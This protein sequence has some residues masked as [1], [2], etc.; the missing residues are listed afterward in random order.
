MACVVFNAFGVAFLYSLFLFVA[1]VVVQDDPEG[2]Q[3][4]PE[5][6]KALQH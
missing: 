2:H 3:E 6:A 5:W 1:G 4:F